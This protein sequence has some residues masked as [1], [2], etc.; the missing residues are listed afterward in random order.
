[1]KRLL[2]LALLIPALAFAAG[3]VTTPGTPV[4]SHVSGQ[5]DRVRIPITF[6]ADDGTAAITSYV[7][8]P[9]VYGIMGYYLYSVEVNP[10]ATGPTNGAW[11]LDITDADGFVVSRNA[12]DDQ[13]S[14]ATNIIIMGPYGFPNIE[15]DWTISIGDNAVNSANV[16]VYLT[17]TSN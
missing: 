9:D 2:L 1:M 4:I 8:Q 17:F 6:T 7:L 14:T 12:I 13:S 3:Q 11:D 16:V 10:G 5:A 15:T